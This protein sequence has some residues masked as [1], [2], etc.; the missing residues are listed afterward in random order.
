MHFTHIAEQILCS[1][2]SKS[3]WQMWLIQIFLIVDVSR[4]VKLVIKLFFFN[5]TNLIKWQ[6]SALENR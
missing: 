1:D 6:Q 4:R 2:Y 3:F 5:Y